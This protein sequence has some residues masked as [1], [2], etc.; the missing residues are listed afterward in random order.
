[1]E[2]ESTNS[3]RQFLESLLYDGVVALSSNIAPSDF[4]MNEALDV[5]VEFEKKLRVEMPA[6]C[7]AFDEKVAN[8]AGVSLFR[9]CQ[10]L[11][12]R[13]IGN[14]EIAATFSKECPEATPSAKH[15]SVDV[16]FR[17]L[18]DLWRI[19]KTLSDNDLLT[20]Y[21][22]QW[23]FQW[24]VSS[25]GIDLG[26]LTNQDFENQADLVEF[27]STQTTNHVS[28]Q[29]TSHEIDNVSPKLLNQ[30]NLDEIVND[31]FLMHVYCERIIERKDKSRISNPLVNKYLC[32]MAGAYRELIGK[33]LQPDIIQESLGEK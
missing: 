31:D 19:A 4:Q 28:T 29:P 13:D 8:W 23:C 26:I 9:A 1:M 18:P 22:R 16:V 2:T 24:P 12:F 15:Y 3:Y 5:L 10:F 17:F 25:V 14:D 21:L 11:Y 33:D 30:L 7:P 32:S 6:N 27:D 20:K